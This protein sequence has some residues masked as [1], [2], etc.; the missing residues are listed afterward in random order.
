MRSERRWSIS[1]LPVTPSRWQKA[2]SDKRANF[3][4]VVTTAA[5]VGEKP[6]SLSPW[7][8]KGSTDSDRRKSTDGESGSGS[9]GGG[10]GGG[11]SPQQQMLEEMARRIRF[12]DLDT[13]G[14]LSNATHMLLYLNK[15]TWQGD[16]PI[17]GL[18][19]GASPGPG[20]SRL[21][22]PVA[23][24]AS[25]GA[26]PGT[27]VDRRCDVEEPEIAA[28]VRRARAAG[29]P[30][31]MVHE[32]EEACGGCPFERFVYQ[33]PYDLIAGGLY[34][35]LAV[36]LHPSP[37]ETAVALVQVFQKLASTAKDGAPGGRR[38]NQLAHSSRDA[39]KKITCHL[40]GRSSSR[41]TDMPSRKM[42]RMSKRMSS[43]ELIIPMGE[44]SEKRKSRAF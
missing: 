13:C 25:P 31:V 14:D 43:A 15:H 5:A 42:G 16:A 17:G 10:G 41:Y 44:M 12:A 29:V 33:T 27:D 36:A 32:Q 35:E 24:G 40:S 30:I 1:S 3:A 39:A 4:S 2:R 19:G 26:S 8:R 11:A 20:G 7:G 21:S 22:T 28:T 38:T 34:N 23:A 18:S 37:E 9:G 6:L